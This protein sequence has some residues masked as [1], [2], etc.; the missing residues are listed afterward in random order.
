MKIQL[1]GLSRDGTECNSWTVK[2]NRDQAIVY[3]DMVNSGMMKEPSGKPW[4]K[5]VA[6]IITP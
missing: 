1:T 4:P 2:L 3:V 6:Y 5:T